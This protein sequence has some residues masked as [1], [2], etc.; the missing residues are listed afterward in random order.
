MS[1]TSN[2]VIDQM[3]K[4]ASSYKQGWEEN[5][6]KERPVFWKNTEERTGKSIFDLLIGI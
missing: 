3:N 6:I 4:K 5:R 1:Q 2:F